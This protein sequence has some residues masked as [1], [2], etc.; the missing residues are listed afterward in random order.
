M[1]DQQNHPGYGAREEAEGED[2][3]DACYQ[4]D[5]S[6]QL[7]CIPDCLFP[8]LPDD[9]H[10]AVHQDD[11]GD[12]NLG[13]EDEF[14]YNVDNLKSEERITLNVTYSTS[15]THFLIVWPFYSY[16][17]YTGKAPDSCLTTFQNIFHYC[18]YVKS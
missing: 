18:V 5:C 15:I 1:G 9:T 16:K 10:C 12:D 2:H 14:S 17:L 6:L 13:K 3:H 8:E 11:E 4:K 7:G